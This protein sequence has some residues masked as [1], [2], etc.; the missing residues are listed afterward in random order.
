[1]MTPYNIETVVVNSEEEH[2]TFQKRV[3]NEQLKPGESWESKDDPGYS[4]DDVWRQKFFDGKG[5]HRITMVCG[6]RRFLFS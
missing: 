5:E 3:E 4:H 6:D 1:M 2:S